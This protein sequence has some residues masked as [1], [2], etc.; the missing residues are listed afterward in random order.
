MYLRELSLN[1]N[2]NN[3]GIINP[4][5]FKNLGQIIPITDVSRPWVERLLAEKLTNPLHGLPPV[6]TLLKLYKHNRNS[7]SQKN[8]PN[9]SHGSL[10]GSTLLT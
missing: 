4:M 1:I 5:S 8:S 2:I 7:Y 6:S 10:P 3:T 9:P